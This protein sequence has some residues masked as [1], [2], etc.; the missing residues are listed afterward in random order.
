MTNW[1]DNLR[2][3]KQQV[4]PRI[5]IYGGH[6]IGKSTLASQFPN[7]IFISTEDGL[8]S[9]DVTSFPR[10][11][12]ISDVVNS[13]KT[14]IKEEHDFKTVVVDTVDWLVEPLISDSVNAQYDEKAQSFGK[15]QMYMAEEFREI[16]QGLEALTVKRGMNVVLIAHAA[17]VKYLDPRTDEYDRYQPKLAKACNALLQEWVD[18]LAFATFKVIIKKSDAKGFETARTRGTTNGERLLH[19]VESPAYV[20]KNRYACPDEI[21]MSFEALCKVIPISGV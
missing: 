13:I 9:L 17:V 15:G 6:G 7:P 10:A 8:N 16:L 11:T 12:L 3:G 14:L 1:K 5:C 4:P 19:L 20:A 18:V 2:V 21:E